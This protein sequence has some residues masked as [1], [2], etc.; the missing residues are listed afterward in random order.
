LRREPSGSGV[1]RRGDDGAAAVTNRGT[2]PERFS[3]RPTDWRTLADGSTA[4]ERPGA[5]GPN[6]ITPDLSL[7]SYQFILQPGERRELSLLLA[8]PA[9]FPLTPAS[10]W[11]GFLVSAAVVS[12]PASAV[13]VAATVFAYENVGAPRRH[14]AMQSMRV[15]QKQDG[16]SDLVARLRNDSPGYCRASAHVLI[17]QAGRI[18]RDDKVSVSTVFPGS[19]RILTQALGKLAPGNYRVEVAIDYGGDSILDGTTDAHVH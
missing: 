11:G 18:V 16:T 7:S 3:A 17:E 9:Q 13:G 14:L 10:Y 12:A 4:L 1:G 15:V 8:I 2:E 19:T 6:S 5:E